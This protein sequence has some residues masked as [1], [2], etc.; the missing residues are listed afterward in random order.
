VARQL[1]EE[2]GWLAYQSFGQREAMEPYQSLLEQSVE[3]SVRPGVD[4]RVL[5]LASAL[6]TGKGYSSAQAIDIPALLE[7]ISSAIADGATGIAIGNGFDPG[8]WEARELFDVP[9]LGLFETTALFA[10]RVGWKVGVICSGRAGPARVEELVA[11]YGIGARMT[12]P[13]SL[14]VSVPE[15]M[16]A[17]RNP[18]L[19][20]RLIASAGD[21]ANEL[22]RRGAE[23]AFVASGALETF[24][25]SADAQPKIGLPLLPG[26][27]IL[28]RELETAVAL[29]ELGV[30]S[31]SRV[32]RFMH[33]PSAV[34]SALS[35]RR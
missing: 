11:R 23:V 32:G 19:K 7:S 30:P 18:E 31:A 26:V 1:T 13:V 35:L 29:T 14:G 21:A 5:R 34:R 6:V 28:M 10:L 17:F 20:D 16:E 2:S 12:A 33:P 24:L 15:I 25:R 27:A 9:V 3:Q 4:A 22:A 8:L